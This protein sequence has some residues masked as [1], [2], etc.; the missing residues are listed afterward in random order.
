MIVRFNP[1]RLPASLVKVSAEAA[2]FAALHAFGA[3]EHELALPTPLRTR[4]VHEIHADV[5][6]TSAVASR[7]AE[8]AS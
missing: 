3:A 1:V 2:A 8:A 7:L 5:L 4:P 6:R